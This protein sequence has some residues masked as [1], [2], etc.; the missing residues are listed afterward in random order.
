MYVS[1]VLLWYTFE[2]LYVFVDPVYVDGDGFVND[3]QGWVHPHHRGQQGRRHQREEG[4]DQHPES[5]ERV[6]CEE[7]NQCYLETNTAI[8][9]CQS[10]IGSADMNTLAA[11]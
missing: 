1:F 7:N 5:L 4:Q 11:W 10:Q 2:V 3:L 9:G 6:G 8:S